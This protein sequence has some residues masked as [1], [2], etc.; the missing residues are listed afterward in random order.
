MAKK[1]EDGQVFTAT[2]DVL[3]ANGYAGATT[4]LIAE[5]AGINE[6]TLFRKY[7][8]KER[9]VSAALQHERATLEL[10]PVAYTGDLAADLLQMVRVYSEASPR[11][12]A[13][14][15]LVMAEV[16]RHPE[17][18]ETIQVPFMLVSR[19]GQ[20]IVRY[21][22]EGR[23]RPGEPVLIAGALLGPVIINTMLRSANTDLPIPPIDLVAHVET[24]LHGHAV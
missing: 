4:R 19:F 13:L 17:L 24:F 22:A 9:L 8:S 23:L 11:Q 10:H 7:G 5:E 2:V 21:Q 1:I 20:I 16:V 3:L 6:V 15:M 14:M 12:S 18:R